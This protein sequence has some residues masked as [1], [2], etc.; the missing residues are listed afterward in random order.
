MSEAATLSESNRQHWDELAKSYDEKPWA[1][2]I[3]RDIAN[4]VEK[5]RDWIGVDWVNKDVSG[6][7]GREVRMLDYACGPGNVASVRGTVNTKHSI[8]VANIATQ[9]LF[10]YVTQ[11][12]GIDLS[13]GMVKEFN[14]R[15]E[16]LGLSPDQFHALEG[17]L[18]ADP[19]TQSAIGG[20]EFFN[21]D[22]VTCSLAFHHIENSELASRRFV[23]RLKPGTG[24]LLII[25]LV[26]HDGHHHGHG[27]AHGHGNGHAHEKG[28][29]HG[30]EQADS[31]QSRWG[32]FPAHPVDSTIAHL[33]F[34][35]DRME[36]L[37]KGAGCVDVEYME[38]DKELAFGPEFADKKTRAF[39]VRGRRAE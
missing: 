11:V 3:V 17:D 35:K 14:R 27:H 38:L 25:D 34:T 9:T 37:L 6:H 33:G 8:L 4:G 28:H 31:K 16:A 29:D 22:L 23:E 36:S 26:P 39:M 18:L 32:P 20:E 10:P 2:D 15:A 5:N 13:S 21:F 12:R 30:S 24:V 1:K 19:A 7:S